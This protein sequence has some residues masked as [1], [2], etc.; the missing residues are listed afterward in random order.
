MTTRSTTHTPAKAALGAAVAAALLSAAATAGETVR[1]SVGERGSSGRS[2]ALALDGRLVAFETPDAL[3]SADKDSDE[4]IYVR[5]TKTGEVWIAS[6]HSDG[7]VANGDSRQPAISE[8]GRYVAFESDATNLVANDTNGLT[9]VFVHDLETRQTERVSVATNGA[10]GSGDS[11]W[12]SIS[13]DGRYV[14]FDSLASDLAPGDGNTDLFDV[15]LHD[16]QTGA[17]TRVTG[18]DGES[19]CSRISADGRFV[20]FYSESSDLVAGVS[21][22]APKVFVYARESA[23]TTLVS[24]GL[25][26]AAPNGASLCP[27]LSADGRYV[28]FDSSASNLVVGDV[29]GAT[30]I[31]VVDR[32]TGDTFLASVSSSGAQGDDSCY[33]PSISASGRYVAFESAATNLVKNDGNGEL[34]VF[35]HDL[36][37]GKTIRVSV[38]DKG[39]EGALGSTWAAIS[40]SGRHT[41]FH[42]PTSFVDDDDGGD[43]VYIHDRKKK[44]TRRASVSADVGGAEALASFDPSISANGRYVAF[45]SFAAL[46]VEDTEGHRDIFVRDVTAGVTERVS[47]SSDG[48]AGV[49]DSMSAVISGN[50]RF[51][52]FASFAENLVPGDTNAAQDVFVHDRKTGLTERMSVDPAG[53]QSFAHS[54]DPSISADGRYVSFRSDAALLAS[55]TNL[56]TDVYV[57]DRKKG[58]LELISVSSTGAPGNDGALPFPRISATGRYVVFASLAT[59]FDADVNGVADVFVRD[60]KKGTTTRVSRLPS[61]VGGDA[62]SRLPSISANGRYVVF[63][64][65]STNLVA[66]DTNG[67]LDV[68]LV[69]RKTGAVTRVSTSTEGAEADIAAVHAEISADGRWIAFQSQ[70]STLLVPD[71]NGA[72]DTYLRDRKK[73][74]LL[75]VSRTTDGEFTNHHTAGRIGLS[76]NG[77][78][79][80]SRTLATN[81][82]EGDDNEAH[83]IY[84]FDRK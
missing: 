41:A 14:A 3:V 74:T 30:D 84:R 29:N 76:S 9:D 56:K 35:V 19:A 36:K 22:G 32:Q 67:I 81:L 61:G 16:R 80:A 83:D 69:D 5:D 1:V 2:P 27:S 28:A 37:K 70:A 31:F 18:G 23:T 8:D 11:S 6:V 72:T 54:Y 64:S 82:A 58:T 52:A 51:V 7:T 24:V 60:R 10:Q 57:R 71:L 15:F 62:E 47:V 39:A 50:G 77:R 65:A 17:T 68:F 63:E 43:D 59:N 12:S 4:D 53:A 33:Q 20:G 66:G 42:S 78:Y 34:D 26:G 38:G 45:D 13:A 79:I 48:A 21:G 49:A 25:N 40:S 55:D 46:V 44:K 75:R 73:G